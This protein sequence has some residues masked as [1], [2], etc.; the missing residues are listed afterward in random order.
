MRLNGEISFSSR[1]LFFIAPSAYP[2]G[3]VATWLDYIIPGLEKKGWNITLGLV[4]GKFHDVDKYLM[5]HPVRNSVKI[6]NKTGSREGRI[7]SIMREI[8]KI[9]PDIVA[10]VNIPD[11]YAAVERMRGKKSNRPK[12]VMTI[13]GIQPD[14]YEDAREFSHILDGVICTNRLACKLAEEEA[15]IKPERIFYAPYGVVI[16]ESMQR[17]KTEDNILRIAYTGRLDNFQKRINDIPEILLN[18]KKKGITFQCLIAGGG[19]AEKVFLEK[20]EEFGL[21]DSVNFF[22]SLP[23]NEVIQKVYLAADILL[24]TS[25]W[26][27]GPIVAW[28]AMSYGLAIVTSQYIGAGLEGSLRD[29]TNCLLFPIGDT[30][31]AAECI[32][33][34]INHDLRSK[35]ISEGHELLQKPYSHQSSIDHWDR[36]FQEIK[37]KPQQK[38]IIKSKSLPATGRLDRF[39]GNRFAETIRQKLGRQFIHNNPG[40]EWPH[41]YGKRR[42]DDKAFW[43]TA[44]L[45]DK[46]SI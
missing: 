35:I 15:G 39:F 26:E 44:I 2:L 17:S 43:D 9:H 30:K 32:E 4:A 33:A 41:S 34:L 22:G 37:S 13:H 11:T 40:G 36:A 12:A 45:L 19:P 1:K 20:I 14:L 46:T 31:K 38:S 27:T 24:I 18:L 16:P 6:G 5:A 23:Y 25:Y 21:S 8:E 29:G 28:E 10:G 42:E 7:R 3:G